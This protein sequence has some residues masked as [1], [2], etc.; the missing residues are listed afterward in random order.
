MPIPGIE[1]LPLGDDGTRLT[2]ERMREAVALAVTH[3][4]VRWFAVDCARRARAGDIP[5]QVAAIRGF[6]A[7]HVHF[8]PDPLTVEW[9][10]PPPALL[11]TI[12]DRF[13]TMADCDDVAT[14]GAALGGAIGIPSRFV[15]LGFVH[16]NAPMG[17]VYTELFDG[18]QWVEL[19]IT[20]SVQHLPMV[21]MVS[22]RWIVPVLPGEG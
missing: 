11:Q 1:A 15:V 13:Y 5:G 21:G 20:R 10:T 8:V 12:V 3:P 7:Q 9:L 6:L 18:A 4:L 19:D 16:P 2:L 14:L 17:H 22:R